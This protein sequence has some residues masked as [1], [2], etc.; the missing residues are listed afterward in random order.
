M[1]G[2]P[3]AEALGSATCL[4]AGEH[5]GD[6][7]QVVV[8]EIDSVTA[9]SE[10]GLATFRWKRQSAGA[11]EA[12]GVDTSVSLLTLADGVRIKWVPGPGKDFYRGDRWSI[13]ATG[14]Q[15][16][17]RSWTATATTPGEPPP[18]PGSGSERTWAR[19]GECGPWCWPTT[20]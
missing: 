9:G 7:D 15:G 13:L 12:T 2:L 1:V 6:L 5:T 4:A 19:P 17:R 10:V 8:V 3:A 16:P 18:A 14:R 20:T 11:W